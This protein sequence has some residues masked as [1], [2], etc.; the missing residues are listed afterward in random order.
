M[1]MPRALPPLN[2]LRAFEAAGRLGSFTKAATELNVSHSA[3]SRHV[4]G[5]EERLNV[6]LF[7]SK[8]T[9][10]ELTDQGRAYLAEITPALDQIA[11]ATE[12][13][14]VPPEGTVTLTTES[15]IAQKWLVPRLAN[16][17]MRHPDIDLQVSVTTQVMDIE[18][19]EF[20]IGL[21]Y[22]RSKPPTG[23]ELLFP[24]TVRAYAAPGFAPEANGKLD[25]MALATGPL[26]E[27]A[28]FRLWPDWFKRAGLENVPDLKLPHPLGA[29]LAIQSAVAGLGAV[30]VDENLCG[31]ELHSGAIVELSPVEISFGG[32]Y[33]AVNSRA[34]RRK[35]VRAVRQWLLD[36]CNKSE[37]PET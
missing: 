26:I 9:G 32:Y 3:I 13:L 18:A 4:R 1:R 22:L 10:V 35:A 33:L 37:E 34:G 11:Q 36:E 30:L 20:D 21:R 17:K 19:H 7:R 6:H 27:E 2:A 31:P 25:L 14:S 8:N 5:L 28:T 23:Y 29:L 16:L 24:S 15:T 12:V